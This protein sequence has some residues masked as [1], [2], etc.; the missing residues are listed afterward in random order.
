LLGEYDGAGKAIQETVYLGDLPVS[1]LKPGTNGSRSTPGPLGVN[2]VYADHLSTPRV[3]ARASD[4]KMVWRW[5]NADPFGLDQPD[6][7]PSKLG[8]LNYNPRLPGQLFDKET[9]NH[10]NYFRD[11]DP[12][13][14]RYLQSDPIGLVGG[15]NTY[16]YVGGNPLSHFDLRGLTPGDP[17]KTALGAAIQAIREI[18]NRSISEDVEYA[19]R[20]YR[21]KDQ[22]YS[23][24]APRRGTRNTSDPGVC[25]SGT[26]RVGGYHTHGD[27][28]LFY[29]D[30]NFSDE[31]LDITDQEK[32][33]G[34]LGTPNGDIKIYVPIAGKPREGTVIVIK[35]G[36]K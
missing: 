2:Y 34:A 35:G 32:G 31:D 30:E 18:N 11:Y 20:I 29:D 24:T 27:K 9:N 22:S 33:I 13:M 5:D 7:N 1:V 17:Y 3:L 28:R 15:L 26:K 8:E 4:N 6:Q 19:G 23:Y 36:A 14:G 12:Q 16:A 25:P 10:Y 21:N